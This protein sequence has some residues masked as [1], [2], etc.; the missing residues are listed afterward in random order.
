MTWQNKNRTREQLLQ[1]PAKTTGGGGFFDNQKKKKEK[2]G[3][4]TNDV[5]WRDGDC[6]GAADR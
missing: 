4:Y 1:N 2:G 3:S 6:G 5:T